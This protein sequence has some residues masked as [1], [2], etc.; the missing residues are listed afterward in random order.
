MLLEDILKQ[1]N[2]GIFMVPIERNL[3][4]ELFAIILLGAIVAAVTKISSQVV[5][6]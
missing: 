6:L 2:L 1:I 3:F 4:I 5:P